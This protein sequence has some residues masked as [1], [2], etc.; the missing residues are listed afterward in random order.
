MGDAIQA[1]KAGILEIG[2]VYVVNKADRDG[3]DAT[4][5]ELQHMLALGERRQPGDWRPPIVKTVA[6]R[7]EGIDEVVEALEKHRG[8]L[9]EPGELRPAAAAAGRRRGRG[10][11]GHGAARPGWATCARRTAGPAWT[12]SPPRSS[13]AG[14][15]RTR[16]PTAWSRASPANRGLAATASVLVLGSAVP[17]GRAASGTVVDSVGS[18][19]LVG[20]DVVVVGRS[21]LARRRGPTQ[22]K[23]DVLVRGVA[24]ADQAPGSALGVQRVLPG[25]QAADPER[26][27]V[28]RGPATLT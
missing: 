26:V 24:A 13:P 20:C 10:D 4:V 28:A 23:V 5:R 7:G 12:S 9:E 18:G 6:A 2:D 21:V 11:R 27:A 1:A 14:P 19:V 22:V 25:R 15:T 3:A 16:R 8:W 17:A